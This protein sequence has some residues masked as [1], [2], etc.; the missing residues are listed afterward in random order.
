MGT[1][2][3][4]PLALNS[5]PLL[6]FVQKI[7]SC[8]ALLVSQRPPTL[9]VAT[10]DVVVGSNSNVLQSH[11]KPGYS[12]MFEWVLMKETDKVLQT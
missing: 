11:A 2:A 7:C 12:T 10:L 9:K 4:S 3:T 6:G 5:S 8:F 1:H